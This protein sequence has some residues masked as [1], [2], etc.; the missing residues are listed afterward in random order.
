[1]SIPYS[2]LSSNDSK[3]IS[4][5]T[6][7]YY[8]NFAKSIIKNKKIYFKKNNKDN[9][10]SN[11]EGDLLILPDEYSKIIF[12]WFSE[13]PLNRKIQL[14]S[15]N[16][17]WLTRIINQLIYLYNPNLIKSNNQYSIKL[18]PI[19]DLK[20]FFQNNN[21]NNTKEIN[22]NELNF[23]QTYFQ[24]DYTKD[25]NG[26][27]NNLVIINLINNIKFF[28]F[29]EGNDTISLN[30]S[31]LENPGK[32][33]EIF[34]SISVQ[35][36]LKSWIDVYFNDNYKMYNFTFPDWLKKKESF[37]LFELLIGYIEQNIILNYEYYL[38]TNRIYENKL[39][40]KIF[41]IFR[42]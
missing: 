5:T 1:M 21:Q 3:V 4:N 26:K 38:Y 9:P 25:N 27:Y 24:I 15:I 8:Q 20:E 23:Y 22:G 11:P 33:K 32:I 14:C 41:E 31:F 37:T 12:E 34:E 13:L 40:D 39:G 7:Q 6:I 17:K 35:N 18:I 42:I 2:I 29:E 16:N 10:F 19:Y 28:S 30:K 36:F